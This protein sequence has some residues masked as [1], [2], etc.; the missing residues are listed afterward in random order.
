MELNRLLNKLGRIY[1]RK[2][3][4]FYDNCRYQFG[5][6]NKEIRRIA[7][8]LDFSLDVY[9]SLKDKDVDLVI[10]RHP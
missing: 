2:L 5:R 8:C 6:N 7:L 4:E 10:S 9:E 3:Q 1:P